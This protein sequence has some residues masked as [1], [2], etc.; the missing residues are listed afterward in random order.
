MAKKIVYKAKVTIKAPRSNSKDGYGILNKYGDFW[1]PHLFTSE[2]A[3]K[4][5]LIEYWKQPGFEKT[6]AKLSDFK[7]VPA[8]SRITARRVSATM[9]KEG[10]R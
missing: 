4:E 6:R 10:G 9:A 5:Y 7:V 8:R 3:A 1:S 2:G